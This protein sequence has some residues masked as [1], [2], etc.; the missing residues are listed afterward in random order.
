MDKLNELFRKTD[1]L[2]QEYIGFWRDLCEIESPTLYKE[3]VD[4]VG[5]TV[6]EKAKSYGF[7]I[8]RHPFEKA[9]DCYTITMNPEAAKK[10]IVLSAHMDTVHQLGSFSSPRTRIEGDKL[11]GPG[12]TDDKGGLACALYAMAVLKEIGFRERPVKFI[13][14]CDEEAASSTSEL[15]SIDYMYEKS[16]DC[17]CF[18]NLEWYR[19]GQAI[20]WRK[21][22]FQATVKV[23]GLS[24]HDSRCFLGHS[25]IRQASRMIN[26]LE[27][28][29]DPEG[30]TCNV[31]LIKGG[32]YKTSV[33]DYCEFSFSVNYMTKGQYDE[34]MEKIH[35]LCEKPY[36]EGTSCEIEFTA[37]FPNMEKKDD[38]FEILE[39]MNRI[40]EKAGMRRIEATWSHGGSDASRMAQMGITTI[41]SFGVH[42]TKIHT[43]EEEAD[44]SS[45]KDAARRLA[46]VIMY[47]ED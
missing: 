5:R 6:A 31:A 1:E 43:P 3:G 21:G 27:E 47:I 42:G 24:Y 2:E 36:V 40:Y 46:A 45:L 15:K 35:D 32:Q 23:H 29:K 14:Q 37:A 9:G 19:Y 38:A 13:L 33:P 4:E 11:Y 44:L 34:I 7:E 30:I 12:V 26:E 8:E 28:Y 10:P 25:A 18:F 41:D 17:L 20:L 39:K 22:C 16:R